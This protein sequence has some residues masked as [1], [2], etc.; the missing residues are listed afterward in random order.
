MIFKKVNIKILFFILFLIKGL[1]FYAQD[2]TFKY[3]LDSFWVNSYT[4][5]INCQP[6]LNFIYHSPDENDYKVYK[7]YRYLINQLPTEKNHERYSEL[8]YALWHLK[9]ISQAEKMFLNIVNSKIK[10]Y[11]STYYH[12]SDIS[13][14]TTTNLYGYGSFSSNYKDAAYIYLTKIYVEQ[15]KFQNA[16]FYLGKAEKKYKVTYTC[17]TGYKAQQDE[18]NFLYAACY[19]GLGKNAKVL[20]LLLPGCFSWDSQILIRSIKKMYP[21]KEIKKY[22]IK[23]E[24]SIT[25]SVDTFQSISYITSNY[26]QEEEKTDTIKYYGGSGTITLFGRKIS[27]PYP[28][29][30]DGERLTKNYYIK[31]FKGTSFYESLSNKKLISLVE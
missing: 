8:A 17:G 9:K 26:G 3:S 23:A 16:L 22:L 10:S 19:E 7:S 13:G 15:K 25:C 5:F 31:L 12:S 28:N 24:K 18:Y 11:N 20:D 1:N 4:S 2:S 6:E 29:L 27:L 30:E 14:D 21:E